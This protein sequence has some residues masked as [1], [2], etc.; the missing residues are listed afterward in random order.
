MDKK[1]I[2]EV[3]KIKL[4]YSGELLIFSIV[5]IVLGLLQLFGV[6]GLSETFLNIFK[7]ITLIGAAYFI[8]DIVTLFT[9]KAKREKACIPDKISTILVPPYIIVID[10]FLWSKNEYIWANPQYFIAPLFLVIAAAYLFQAIYHWFNPLK[11]LFED[12]EKNTED[13]TVLGE[14]DLTEEKEKSDI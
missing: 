14:I 5:F 9:N 2:D 8:Y 6:I 13:K 12:D 11:E 1:K 4:I 7:I 3:T 10:I